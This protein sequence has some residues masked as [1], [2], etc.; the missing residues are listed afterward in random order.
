MEITHHF[1]QTNQVRLH[2]A[3]CGPEDGPLVILLHG[4]PEYWGAW[5]VHM[6]ALADEGYHV[7]APDQRGYNASDKPPRVR[8]YRIDELALDVVGLIDHCGVQEARIVGHDWGGAVAWQVARAYP[9]R[10]QQVAVINCPPI[11]V[12]QRYAVWHPVQ[13][14]RSWYMFV[15]QAPWLVP[16]A[17]ALRDFDLTCRQFVATSVPG[18]FSR[19]KLAG[20]MEA[21]AQPGALRSMVHWYRAAFWY[22]PKTGLGPVEVPALFLW[23]EGDR[24]LDKGLIEPTLAICTSGRLVRYPDASHWLPHEEAADVVGQL[25]SFFR[26]SDDDSGGTIRSHTPP[27]E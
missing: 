20:H 21:W 13:L 15:M 19:E 18:T 23:G 22:P 4:F 24:F 10:I 2:V 12:A 8:D 17:M 16:W 26:L 27:S 5:R 6:E 1:I 7:L 9:E 25:S 11:D 14:L 3:S